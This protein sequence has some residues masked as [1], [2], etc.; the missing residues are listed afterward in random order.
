MTNSAYYNAYALVVGGGFFVLAVYSTFKMVQLPFSRLDPVL[1]TV[2]SFVAGALEILVGYVSMLGFGGR[3]SIGIARFAARAGGSKQV[4]EVIPEKPHSWFGRL[5]GTAYLV[6]VPALVFLISVALSWDIF[7][8]DTIHSGLAQ[9]FFHL[10][11]IFARN[12]RVNPIR[13]SLELIPILL[14]LTFAAGIVPSI[15]LPY[16]GKFRV[17]GVNS[18]PFHTGLLIAT[19]GVVTGISAIFSLSALFYETLFTSQ[20]PLYYHY[21]LL[22]MVGMSLYYAVGTSLGLEMAG[23]RIQKTLETSN[24]D[25]LVFRGTVTLN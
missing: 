24:P 25:D 6:Y 19:V 18:S 22:Q 8:L 14:L 23:A 10:L 7:T 15:V 21:S 12:F 20:E 16:F 1:L 5:I 11:D 9:P 3:F 2:V 4:L 17:T 13:F